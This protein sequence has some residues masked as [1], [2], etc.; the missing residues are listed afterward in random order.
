MCFTIFSLD[1]SDL[2]VPRRHDSV[3]TIINSHFSHNRRK[4]GIAEGS[5][6]KSPKAIFLDTYF[7]AAIGFVSALMVVQAI[8]NSSKNASLVITDSDDDI[9]CVISIVIWIIINSGIQ[10]MDR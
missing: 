1:P 9:F 5:I 4:N 3:S 8:L 10:E 7:Y 2:A 6:P